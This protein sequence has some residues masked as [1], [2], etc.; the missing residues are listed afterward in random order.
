MNRRPFAG[1]H[2]PPV[3]SPISA[4]AVWKRLFIKPLLKRSVKTAYLVYPIEL[5]DILS[6]GEVGS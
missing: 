3:T 2:L 4:H 5:G 1:P 6:T